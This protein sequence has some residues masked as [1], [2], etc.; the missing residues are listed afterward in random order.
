MNMDLKFRKLC[1][2]KNQILNLKIRK[3]LKI[4]RKNK[5]KLNKKRDMTQ[6]EKIYI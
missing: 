4:D 6:K 1:F 3:L 5:I 2:Y